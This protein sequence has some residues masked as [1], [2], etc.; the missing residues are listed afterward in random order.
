VTLARPHAHVP[1]PLFKNKKQHD[2]R[3]YMTGES[4]APEYA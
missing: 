3:D 4:A 1:D 2:G